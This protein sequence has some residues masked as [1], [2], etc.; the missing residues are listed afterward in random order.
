MHLMSVLVEADGS[1]AI[2]VIIANDVHLQLVDAL[3]AEKSPHDERALPD[4]LGVPAEGDDHAGIVV[5]HL[6][7]LEPNVHPQGERPG[8]EPERPDHGLLRPSLEVR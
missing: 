1:Y 2:C 7:E 8:P 5:P 4:A 3:V 6:H